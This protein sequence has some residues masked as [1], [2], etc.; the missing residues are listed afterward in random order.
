MAADGQAQRLISCFTAANSKNCRLSDVVQVRYTVV[1][2]T[3]NIMSYT[4]S[5]M[6]YDEVEVADVISTPEE[7]IRAVYDSSGKVHPPKY[8]ELTLCKYSG[9]W[10]C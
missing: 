10:G 9:C 4:S 3:I 5:T 7:T 6:F 1:C 8:T 2:Y